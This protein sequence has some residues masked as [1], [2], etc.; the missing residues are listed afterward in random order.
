MPKYNLMAFTAGGEV[1]S[2]RIIDIIAEDVDIE[3]D[4][5]IEAFTEDTI[6]RNQ[7]E[8]VGHIEI[9]EPTAAEAVA[10]AAVHGCLDVYPPM[11]LHAADVQKLLQAYQK[12]RA[13]LDKSQVTPA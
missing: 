6:R 4:M 5:A 12:L 2:S 7:G 8:F 11:F 10:I 9:P 13:T 1:V 3:L